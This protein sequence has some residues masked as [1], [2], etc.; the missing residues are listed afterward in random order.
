MATMNDGMILHGA[1]LRDARSACAL[2]LDPSSDRSPVPG[3]GHACLLA[4]PEPRP[5][6]TGILAWTEGGARLHP[7]FPPPRRLPVTRTRRDGTGCT[8]WARVRGSV[9]VPGPDDPGKLIIR[10]SPTTHP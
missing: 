6:G 2:G 1:R 5:P 4:L 3:S 9:L 8:R 10:P 7:V